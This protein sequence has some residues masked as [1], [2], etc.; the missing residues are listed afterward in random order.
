MAMDWV[1][2]SIW[3]SRDPCSS[4]R[5]PSSMLL[6]ILSPVNRIALALVLTPRTQFGFHSHVEAEDGTVAPRVKQLEH[7]LEQ[8]SC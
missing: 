8:T 7:I 4:H 3:S 6:S 1:G 2:R 5:F